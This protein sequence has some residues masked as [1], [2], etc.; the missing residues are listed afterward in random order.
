MNHPF[1]TMRFSMEI[2]P[3]IWGSPM[4]METSIHPPRF[5]KKSPGGGRF[6]PDL[7]WH[8]ACRRHGIGDSWDVTIGID[9]W[10]LSGEWDWLNQ[11]K[12]W[13][14]EPDLAVHEDIDGN[15]WKFIV[16][17]QWL[18]NVLNPCWLMIIHMMDDCDDHVGFHYPVSWKLS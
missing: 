12:P 7:V 2:H 1:R 16:F 13:R 6:A 15:I 3:A 9:G 5:C 11:K 17:E 8:V 14:I 10:I 18:L 4:T